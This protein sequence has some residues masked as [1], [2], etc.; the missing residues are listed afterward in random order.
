VPKLGSAAGHVKE[1]MKNAIIDNLDYAF[2]NGIDKDE[3][4]NWK[5]PY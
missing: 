2:T 5:W 3:I 1:R 4:T